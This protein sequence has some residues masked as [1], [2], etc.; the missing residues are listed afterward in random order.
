MPRFTKTQVIVRSLIVSILIGLMLFTIAFFLMYGKVSL[1]KS[2]V[3]KIDGL[4][5]GDIRCN[6]K[7]L[8]L[9]N[10]AIFLVSGRQCRSIL[11]KID[12][13]VPIDVTVYRATSSDETMV[14]TLYIDGYAIIS[15]EA[16]EAQRW[17]VIVGG[18]IPFVVSIGAM[19]F[20]FI[21]GVRDLASQ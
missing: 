1:I 6:T 11:S 14:R 20:L 17:Y 16:S 18:S 12:H 4:T 10:G 8:A 2:D 3:Y 9:P 5:V 15:E 7:Y 21:L 13:S 19:I